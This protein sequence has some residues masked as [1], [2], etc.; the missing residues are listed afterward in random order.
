MKS[1]SDAARRL[2]M[3]E[4]GTLT[5]GE[6]L[7]KRIEQLG[8]Y[9]KVRVLPDDSVAALGKLTYTTAIYLGCT[10]YGY[11]QRF[12]FKD[13]GHALVQFLLLDSED[14]EPEGFIARR[15]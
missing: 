10:S 11:A 4:D 14:D 1:W 15:G 8:D 12:C 5:V 7:A 3:N 9:E 6:Q 13:R 2:T